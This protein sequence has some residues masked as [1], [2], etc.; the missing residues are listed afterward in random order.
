MINDISDK[1][2]DKELL[3]LWSEFRR[4]GKLPDGEF[5]HF[6]KSFGVYYKEFTADEHPVDETYLKEIE[7]DHPSREALARELWLQTEHLWTVFPGFI[8]ALKAKQ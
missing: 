2:A 4:T 5:I 1:Y 7:S 6:R 3:T 8:E